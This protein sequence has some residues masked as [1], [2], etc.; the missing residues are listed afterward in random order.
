MRS[1]SETSRCCDVRQSADQEE[2]EDTL[3]TS[4]KGPSQKAPQYH[5]RSIAK[6]LLAHLAV[7]TRIQSPRSMFR[8][9]ELCKLYHDF[10]GHKNSE[11][12]KLALSC[13]LTYKDDFLTPYNCSDLIDDQT[14]R[15]ELVAFKVDK[16]A[17]VVQDEHRSGLMPVIMRY[18]ATLPYCGAHER[19]SLASVRILFSKMS[20]KTGPRTGGKAGGALRRSLVLKFLAGCEQDEM[21]MFVQMLFDKY[22]RNMQ[23]EPASMV[24]AIHSSLDLAKVPHPKRVL[25]SL[26]LLQVVLQRLGSLMG[27]DVLT[28]LVRVLLWVGGTAW[29]VWEHKA[30]IHPRYTAAFRDIRTSCLEAFTYFFNQF[31]SYPWSTGEIDALFR[32][33]V[34][35]YLDKLPIE[36]I[37]SPTALLKLFS[38]LSKQPRFDTPHTLLPVW[39]T[40]NRQVGWLTLASYFTSKDIRIYL[41]PSPNL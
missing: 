33:M 24:H 27:Y 34:F 23:D 10:L 12:Q 30:D 4:A 29:S 7:F 32:V 31:E 41:C 28:H 19:W 5:A 21:M 38:A 20:A 39:L 26:N 17:E 25:S 6:T 9:P 36:G 40:N 13:V 37:H 2:V 18:S 3:E 16:E 11:I 1:S 8:E 15:N 22:S 35:P 14:F